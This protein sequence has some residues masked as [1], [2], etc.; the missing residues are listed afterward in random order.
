MCEINRFL[1]INSMFTLL[2]TFFVCFATFKIQC[3]W[4]LNFFSNECYIFE[5]GGMLLIRVSL[6][7]LKKR[8]CPWSLNMGLWHITARSSALRACLP[9]YCKSHLYRF[10]NIST[11]VLVQIWK[12]LFNI[13]P[14]KEEYTLSI[15]VRHI[16]TNIVLRRAVCS[17]KLCISHLEL[18]C[19]SLQHLKNRH[20]ISFC[21]THHTC[22]NIIFQK[23]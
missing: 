11:I 7:L 15:C 14:F 21:R 17:C 8:D 4:L 5:E 23:T 13:L 22:W 18:Y 1:G 12:Y 2:K 20:S 9:R 6:A 16:S 10:Y 3:F 19:F